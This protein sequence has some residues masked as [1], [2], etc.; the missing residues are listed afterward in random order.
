MLHLENTANELGKTKKE[1]K[2]N[3]EF[4]QNYNAK[5]QNFKMKDIKIQNLEKR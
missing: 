2:M 5:A 3:K 4:I 1:N